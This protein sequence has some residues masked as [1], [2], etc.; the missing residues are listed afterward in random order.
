MN[1]LLALL[2]TTAMLTP[3]A[4][5]DSLSEPRTTLVHYDDINTNTTR[6]AAVLY[7]RLKAAAEQVCSDQGP[8][9]L[10]RVA[11]HDQCLRHAI[12]E[13][14]AKINS[15]VV[16]EYATTRGITPADAPA[17]AVVLARNPR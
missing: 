12:S 11:R 7:S 2:A 13:A 3:A 9:S 17:A 8:R 4:H 14:V 16:T 6:G 1:K 5:A 15:P 10:A